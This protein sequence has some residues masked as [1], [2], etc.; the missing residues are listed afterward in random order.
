[1]MRLANGAL[2]LLHLAVIGFSVLGWVWPATRPWHL[3]L[4]ALIAF[5]WFVLGPWLGKWGFCFLTGVQH[6]LWKRQGRSELPNYMTFLAQRLTG[7]KPD[8]ARVNVWTQ[9]VFYTTT[10]LSLALYWKQRS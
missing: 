5:S 3:V 10:A 9:A 6:A 4:A 8:P 1:M 2:H 7:R